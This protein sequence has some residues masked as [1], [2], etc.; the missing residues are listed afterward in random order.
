MR[1]LRGDGVRQPG[2]EGVQTVDGA[3]DT[4]ETDAFETDFAHEFSGG[5]A[6]FCGLGGGGSLLKEDAEGVGGIH[7]HCGGCLLTFIHDIA[8][9]SPNSP[10]ASQAGVCVYVELTDTATHE[11]WET[12]LD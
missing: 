5:H 8:S 1:Q 11:G 4:I 3:G 12:W 9:V 6:F 2:L 7:G 10:L